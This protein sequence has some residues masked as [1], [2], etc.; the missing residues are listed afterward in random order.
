M[1]H[2]LSMGACLALEDAAALV[3]AVVS[4][5][6]ATGD[7]NLRPALDRYASRRRREIVRIGRQSRRVGA[8][9]AT[10][11]TSVRQRD[12][13]LGYAPGPL[14]RASQALRSLRRP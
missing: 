4:V 7:S 6:K 9:L 11:R 5:S 2:H 10:T 3:E 12:A 8:A 14:G 1:S 13:A